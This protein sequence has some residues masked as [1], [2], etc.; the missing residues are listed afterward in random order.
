ML[1]VDRLV[2]VL[3]EGLLL[4]EALLMVVTTVVELLGR[5]LWLAGWF[6]FVVLLDVVRDTTPE[7]GGDRGSPVAL[8]MKGH[9]GVRIW[10][11]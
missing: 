4:W 8:R 9:K 7:G 6:P 5:L 2:R 10:R 1:D 11:H 3:L